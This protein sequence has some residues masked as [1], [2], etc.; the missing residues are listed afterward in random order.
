[1]NKFF[2]TCSLVA[3]CLVGYSAIAE[4][5]W[6]QISDSDGVKT[7]QRTVES[8]KIVAFRGETEVDAPIE[9][10]AAVLADVPARKEWIDDLIEGK[11]LETKS[12]LD[13][14]DYNYTHVSWP[15]QDRDLVYSVKVDVNQKDREMKILMKSTE[16]PSMPKRSGIVRAEMLES[17]YFVKELAPNKTFVSI[18]IAVDPKGN[19]PLWLVRLKQRK[20]PRKTLLAF[21]EFAANYSKPIPPEFQAYSKKK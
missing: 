3:A 8:T 13:R 4:N 20:W 18:E 11:N 16:H 6:K 5:D 9:K 14:I 12:L 1:M 21:K 10:V 15:F 19:V 7:F 2:T 17:H